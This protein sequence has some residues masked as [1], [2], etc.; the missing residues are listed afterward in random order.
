MLNFDINMVLRSQNIQNDCQ[1]QLSDSS[2][3]NWFSAGEKGKGD[4]GGGE[5]KGRCDTAPLSQIPGSAPV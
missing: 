4:R 3:Q 1:Q 5:K 2:A